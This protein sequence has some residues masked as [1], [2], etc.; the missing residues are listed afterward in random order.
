MLNS[1]YSVAFRSA[2][3]QHLLSIIIPRVRLS[4]SKPRLQGIHI[5]ITSPEFT[6]G[7]SM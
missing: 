6:S 1:F 3:G 7:S 5:S 4:L 2:T